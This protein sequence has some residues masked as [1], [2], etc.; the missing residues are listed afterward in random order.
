MVDVT[1]P[2]TYR[3]QEMEG[4]GPFAEGG[5]FIPASGQTIELP[6]GS[7]PSTDTFSHDG[8]DL[9]ITTPEGDTLVITDFFMFDPPPDFVAVGGGYCGGE[10]IAHL[11]GPANPGA[12]AGN[13]LHVG[14]PIGQISTVSGDVTVTRINGLKVTLKEGD[15]VF[16][17]DG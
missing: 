14:Q 9:V 6:P 4:F 16:M 1:Q 15:P 13:D 3:V 17:G 8:P 12:F 10:L 7:N 5:A 11:A 2:L